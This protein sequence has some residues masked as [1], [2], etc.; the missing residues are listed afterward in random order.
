MGKIVNLVVLGII[1]AGLMLVAELGLTRLNLPQYPGLYLTGSAGLRQLAVQFGL[2]ALFAVAYGLLIKP[3]LPSAVLP[4]ALV[5]SLLPFICLTMVW[6]LYKGGAVES[7][8]FR[9]LYT[10]LSLFIYSLALIL[11]GRNGKSAKE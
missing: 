2:G 11:L 8:S 5:F 10:E 7:G 3:I 4:A 9:L 6:P 1:A